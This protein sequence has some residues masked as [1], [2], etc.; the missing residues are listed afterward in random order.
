MSD[1]LLCKHPQVLVSIPDPPEILRYAAIVPSHFI[2]LT[3]KVT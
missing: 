3:R 1:S 2:A